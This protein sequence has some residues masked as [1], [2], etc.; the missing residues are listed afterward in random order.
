MKSF[1][2]III[3]FFLL[4]VSGR[5]AFSQEV[6]PVMDTLRL[7]ERADQS[8]ETGNEKQA[9]GQDNKQHQG[10]NNATRSVKQ[11]RNGR[12]DMTRARGA[13]P[14]FIVRPSGSA[15]PRGVGRPGGAG[16][17]GGR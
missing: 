12:P 10:M 7:R 4:V 6:A 1:G 2:K 5:I 11:I 8:S 17:K 14:P 15:M 13:R 9:Q 16:R 3:L